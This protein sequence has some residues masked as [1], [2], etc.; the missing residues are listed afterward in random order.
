[1]A[2]GAAVVLPNPAPMAYG[3]VATRSE[4]VNAL[5][6]RR[7]DQNV[8]V[9]L[10]DR[11]QWHQLAPS[12]DLPPAALDA[13]LIVLAQRLTVLLPL[14]ESV[15]PPDWVAPAIRDGYLAAF[16]GYWVATACLWERFPRLYGSSA[17]LT[18]QPP[19]ATAA[20]AVAMFGT[21]CP[22]VDADGLEDAPGPRS[23]S[24]MVR[25]DRGGRL[26]LHRTGAHDAASGRVPAEYVR[27]LA[28]GVGLST[29]PNG[30]RSRSR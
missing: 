3:V 23:A 1:L 15:P 12:I 4:A 22:V 13:V 21:D 6:G 9:S 29:R 26:G 27:H 2:A 8:A 5:K 16:N 20:Q 17:N 14:R 7:L 25:I 18:G 11:P 28:A 10:H 19:A 24:T 30:M